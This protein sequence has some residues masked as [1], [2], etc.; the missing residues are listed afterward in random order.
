M[1]VAVLPI[2]LRI[3]GTCSNLQK[4]TLLIFRLSAAE[5]IYKAISMRGQPSRSLIVSLADGS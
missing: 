2:H 4:L 3:R 5:Y 1:M